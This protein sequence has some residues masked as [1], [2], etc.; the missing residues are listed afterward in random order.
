MMCTACLRARLPLAEFGDQLVPT[1]ATAT[2]LV[3]TPS[4]T[5]QGPQIAATPPTQPTALPTDPVPAPSPT[6]P[7]G[8][9]GAEYT[10][11]LGDT[12][13]A[14]AY[15]C[16]VSLQTIIALNPAITNLDSIYEGQV[17]TIAADSPPAPSGSADEPLPT[18]TPAV[19]NRYY[20]DSVSGS[21]AYCGTS[22][23]T[24]WRSLNRV[25]V[26]ALWP[27]DVLH[28]RRGGA[29]HG[30]LVI[31][32]S[33]KEG[34][35]ITITAY[36]E[37]PRPVFTHEGPWTR[38]I[39]LRGSWIVLEGVLVRGA[40]EAGVVIEKEASFNVVRD[41]EGEDVGIGILVKGAQNRVANNYLHDLKMVVNTPGGDDDYGAVGVW[42]EAPNN[43]VA[44]NRM[45]R[46]I[47][48]S[49]D[50]GVDGGAVEAY[51][52]TDGSNIHHNYAEACDSFL[53]VGGGSSRDIVLAHNIGYNN[54][55]F[56]TL[57]IGGRFATIV[58]NLTIEHNTIVEAEADAPSHY[59]L[60]FSR[61]TPAPGAVSLRNNLFYLA[62][63]HQMANS[64]ALLH[65]NNLYHLG[66]PYASLG[67][68]LNASELLTDPL[69]VDLAARDLRPG[70]GSPAIDAGLDLGYTHDYAGNDRLQGAAPD[71]G[72][73]ETST[74]PGGQ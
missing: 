33:G 49:Y 57:H 36:G 70:P 50:Y 9:C 67:Y 18:D 63:P 41:I 37:G 28:F 65:E 62:G 14:I 23:D 35:P 32:Y 61:G 47:A 2:E 11:A 74:R 59:L 30:Q 42:L 17:L 40:H 52:N 34:R 12:L 3:M 69:L 46:C 38:V 68:A 16:G 29:W 24:P 71:L 20:V 45:I 64:D 6:E 8:P 22:P 26:Q 1:L 44:H 53:E 13:A 21:D 15:R 51:G 5:C 7:L 54:R 10:V 39:S 48:P 60:R 56:I 27:G 4:P 19:G 73:L 66:H 72:A 31:A 55:G 58:E 43:E 25:H